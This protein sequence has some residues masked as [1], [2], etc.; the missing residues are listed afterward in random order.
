MDSKRG[1]QG[2]AVMPNR[3]KSIAILRLLYVLGPRA[4]K[5]SLNYSPVCMNCPLCGVHR[6]Y[7]TDTAHFSFTETFAIRVETQTGANSL[8]PQTGDNGLG[9][10]CDKSCCH[11]LLLLIYAGYAPTEVDRDME[12]TVVPK[13]LRHVYYGT[14]WT[15]QLT[16]PLRSL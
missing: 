10:A 14:V 6:K 2:N 9:N 8:G 16:R 11:S 1:R 4:S 7:C 12:V 5:A 3:D 15:G 13:R